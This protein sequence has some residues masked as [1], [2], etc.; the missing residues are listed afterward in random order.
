MEL[1]KYADG[2][3]F[4][5]RKIAAAL[6]TTSME[7][8]YAA[9][10]TGPAVQREECI[11][12]DRTQRRLGEMIAVVNKVEPYLGSALMAFAW[13]KS[14][15]LSGFSGFT[16]MQLVRNGRSDEVL[17]YINAVGAGVHA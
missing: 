1:A 13:Y 8:A 6:H 10:L 2:D 7:I 4:V 16:A 5:P 15:P 9:G 12:S 17:A 11:R 3:F 14:E